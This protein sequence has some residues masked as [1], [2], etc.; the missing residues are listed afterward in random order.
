MQRQKAPAT[1]HKTANWK[2]LRLVVIVLVIGQVPVVKLYC[3]EVASPTSALL[4][5][6]PPAAITMP[7]G[8]TTIW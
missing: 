6:W 4:E 7:V 5:F 2:L 1:F 8:W 3:S